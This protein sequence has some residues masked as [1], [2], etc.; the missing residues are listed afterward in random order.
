MLNE[1]EA[2]KVLLI[3]ERSMDIAAQLRTDFMFMS[4]QIQN[5]NAVV[6]EVIPNAGISYTEQLEV[7]DKLLAINQAMVSLASRMEKM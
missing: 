4:Q 3:N 5:L 1:E 2:R 7:R 6:I